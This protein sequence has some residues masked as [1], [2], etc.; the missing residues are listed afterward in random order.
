MPCSPTT[1]ATAPGINRQT[2][3]LQCASLFE[4]QSIRFARHVDNTTLDGRRLTVLIYLNPGWWKESHLIGCWHVFDSLSVRSGR[5]SKEGRW[6]SRSWET[7][8]AAWSGRRGDRRSRAA[9]A[10]VAAVRW[11]TARPS[12][13]IRRAGGWPCSCPLRCPMKS[14]P[15]LETDMRSQSG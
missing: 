7:T 1:P 13:S 10:A 3:C 4:I 15:L 14:C 8:R 12:T 9:A 2:E 6:G 11:T 5:R